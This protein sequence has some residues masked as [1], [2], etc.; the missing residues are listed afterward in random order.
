M[1]CMNLILAEVKVKMFDAFGGGRGS[2][3]NACGI[4]IVDLGCGCSIKH[5][6]VNIA[7]LD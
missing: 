3:L 2:P 7:E 1:S 4:I 6:Q 5:A